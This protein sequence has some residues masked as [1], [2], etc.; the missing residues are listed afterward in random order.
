[1]KLPP[2]GKGA[3]MMMMNGMMNPQMMN[4]PKGLRNCG[5]MP[6][7]NHSQMMNAQKGEKGGGGN[8]K[9]GGGGDG[10]SGGVMPVQVNDGKN[11]N[12]GKKGGGVAGSTNNQPQGGGNK[13]NSNKNGGGNNNKYGNNGHG[14]GGDDNMGKK[15]N[16]MIREGIVQPM[17]NG[18]PNIG[19]GGGAHPSINGANV[20]PIGNMSTPMG[21]PISTNMPMPMNQMGNVPAV[22]RFPT[23]ASPGG[24]DN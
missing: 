14:S 18:M 16:G 5:A 3:Q 2:V 11:G 7:E 21:G 24:I 13:N 15:G 12:G 22:Q 6:H 17:N 10:G 1:M 20:G 9:K 19:N 4:A 23:G 8:G